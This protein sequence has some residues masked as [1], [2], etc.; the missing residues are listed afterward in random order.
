MRDI[1]YLTIVIHNSPRDVVLATELAESNVNQI[2]F[3]GCSAYGVIPQSMEEENNDYEAIPL[4][5]QPRLPPARGS[6][7]TASPQKRTQYENTRVLPSHSQPQELEGD[8][9]VY[10]PTCAPDTTATAMPIIAAHTVV[11]SGDREYEDM[12]CGPVTAIPQDI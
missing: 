3:R 1:Y 6:G 4:K 11:T 5:P 8:E 9:H 10:E 2:S 12:T 7:P